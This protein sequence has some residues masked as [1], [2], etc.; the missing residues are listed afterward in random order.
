M[1]PQRDD[2]RNGPRPARAGVHTALRAWRESLVDLGEN[3]RLINFTAAHA[4]QLEITAPEPDQ[5]VTALTRGARC[6][7]TGP[8]GG[9][10]PDAALRTD[11]PERSL[12]PLLRR[13]MRRAQQ[14]H[15]DRGVAVLHLALGLLHWRLAENDEDADSE[16][17]SHASPLLLLPAE[18]LPGDLGEH[19]E[20][21]LRDEEPVLN[22][23][24]ALRLRQAGIAI[25]ALEPGAELDIGRF[26]SQVTDTVA[27]R[28]GWHIERAVILTCLTF[29]K[30]AIYRDLLENEERILAHPVVRALATTDPRRQTDA[31]R[32]T[33]IRPEEVDR[34][35]PPEDVPLVLDA[36][37][38]QRA[39][40]AAA[41]AGHSFVMDGPPGTG[42]SQTVA[43]M[44]GALLHAGKRVL[45]VSEKVAALD[46]V[47]NRL[48]E[49]GL[50]RYILELHGQQAG[51]REVATL[52]A[53]A[54]DEVPETPGDGPVVDRGLLRER[55]ERLTAFAYAMNET[56]RPLGASL[57]EI[58]GR[59]AGLS[60]APAAPVPTVT[61]GS[62]TPDVMRRV[63]EATDQL[64]R[65]WRAMC[66]GD[67]LLWRDVATREPLDPA[68]SRAEKALAALARSARIADTAARA[69]GLGR[70]DDAATLARLA[71]H[72]G[73]RPGP[74]ADSW[75]TA[76]DLTPIRQAVQRRSDELAAAAAAA[77]A[78]RERAGVA[79]TALP[80]PA[81]LPVVPSLDALPAPVELD[82]LTAADADDLARSF[83]TAAEQLDRHR[84]AV[85]RVTAKLGLPRALTISDIS[86]VAAVAEL[87]TR[88]HKPERFW[89]GPG[90]LAAVQS[91]SSA[92]RRALESLV[93]AEIQARPYFSEA[94]LTQPVE[95]LAERFATVHHGLGKLR[96]AYR[97]DRRQVAG[98]VLPS[99]HLGDAID[100]IGT[101]V[102][103]KRARQE[104]AAAEHAYATALG[105]YWRGRATDFAALDE[106]ISVATA[107]LA[108]APP[109]GV[110][111]V[112][113]YICA[114]APDPEPVRVVGEARD[115]LLRW[116]ATLRPAPY[117][118]ARP[119][120]VSGPIDDA[121]GWLRAHIGALHATADIVRA[122][123]AATGRTLDYAETV[124]LAQLRAAAARAEAALGTG[125]PEVLGADG[126]PGADPA[127]LAAAVS[128]AA[129]ARRF[130]GPGEAPLTAAQVAAL[131]EL[132]PI[133][134]LAERAREWAEASRA[135]LAGFGPARQA[136]LRDRF[137]DYRR[138]AAFLRD[139]RDDSSGQEE[140]FSCLDARDVLTFHGLDAAV[141]FCADQRMDS[142]DVPA[143]LERALL[144][145]WV[146]AVVRTDGRLRP[147]R[148]VDR[149]RLVAEFR[150]A[151]E[152]LAA[153]SAREI[154]MTV[155][156]RRPPADS[157]AAALLRREAM[158]AD[159]QLPVRELI[160]RARDVVLALRPCF[161]ASPLTVSQALPPD[162]RFDAVIFDEASQITPA[163]AINCIYR[164]GALI[165]AGDDRQLPPTS[166]FDRASTTAPDSEVLD[167]QSVLELAK[168]C[169]AFPGMGLTWHY[170]SRHQALVAFANDAFYQGRL[171][172][173][174]APGGSGPD[175]GVEMFPVAGVYRRST[176]RDNPVEAER[177]AERIVHHFTTRPGHTLGV[178]TFSVAQAEAI[179]RALEA[180]AAGH[181]ALQRAVTDDRL[182]GFFVK[183][184]EAVQGDERD[185]MIFSIGYGFDEAGRISANFG[186]LNRPNGWRRL[187]VAITRARHRVEIVTSILSRDVPESENEGVRQLAAYLDYVERGAGDTSLDLTDAPGEFVESVVETIRS[188][189]YPAR[190]GL[191][192]AGGRV[193]IAIRHPDDPS[194]D[195][196]LG[197]RCDG[198]G[199]RDCPAARDRDRLT[200]QVLADL[201]WR[202]HRAWALA[203]YR[204]RAGEEARLRAALERAAAARP[205]RTGSVEGPAAERAPGA[206]P[207]VLR[208]APA[209]K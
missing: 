197:V 30:E 110:E 69:F 5:V 57:H 106:A 108:A 189:G 149:D 190:T 23:A 48:A 147:W 79:W 105:R 85:D 146:D 129:A 34:L 171:S 177:V 4:D 74:V 107:A 41:L 144:H 80:S 70:P 88:A 33:P 83:T 138:A 62:L 116:Q 198:P 166:F 25:P 86:R 32:F 81:D 67:A 114:P 121:I 103:W 136:D 17:V 205:G 77:E 169:G 143:V 36:D 2:D 78:V 58:I 56:R 196:L 15:L 43:N 118:A 100:R 130:A 9:E 180:I 193:D 21:R 50:D 64:A 181:P 28:H 26:W 87:G 194:G 68:L 3:N 188:W 172:T 132:R 97:R 66:D 137:G 89:F 55:R 37:S 112:L 115:A 155:Q 178:V 133:T 124:R 90:V 52:L 174:P 8:G 1:G 46:V 39:C 40:V 168:A 162:I 65:S 142:A 84:R 170:R 148:G 127:A 199:Y 187:N 131:R 122:Y 20:L 75:L 159:R 206:R 53:A 139:I 192:T 126:E 157:T 191:G 175:T 19:P 163:D 16:P 135:V 7:L 176:S 11:L 104:L 101:A 99:A 94:I 195:Y 158:K 145:G 12:G 209:R 73:R 111:A 102:A 164:G 38:S 185:V 51:R 141:E 109:A 173:F 123:D 14:E 61:P 184:L 160:A 91:G 179:E 152:R 150:Q 31:F 202:L 140:W 134:G 22:P 208:A 165:T 60:D 182:H 120:L 151:D 92:L 10:P 204:D 119:E 49:A 200:D 54:V 6:P 63:R 167:Y 24:L 117:P 153:V 44:I 96:A 201:G 93:G 72:A 98:F 161:L 183:S 113:G 82:T 35:A 186:A 95:E 203:W 42:K 18:L 27:R 13:M 59:C 47:R 156:A 29:H 71:E 45:F 76:D 207:R 125:T 154:I 128:W